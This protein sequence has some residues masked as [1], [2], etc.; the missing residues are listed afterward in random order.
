MDRAF[1]ALSHSVRR[2]MLRRLASGPLTVSELAQP[3]T[4]SLAGAS[5]HVQVLVD[6]RLVKRTK[7]GRRHVCRLE[8]DRL[9]AA[10]DW[11]RYYEQFWRQ[12]LDGL[13]NL[14]SSGRTAEEEK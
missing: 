4:M 11:L 13:E 7:M 14:F 12:S 3:L 1:N 8:P 9:E 10:Y 5:K 6:A 2:G